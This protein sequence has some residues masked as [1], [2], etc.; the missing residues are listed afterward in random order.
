[1]TAGNVS[2]SG[3]QYVGTADDPCELV[4]VGSSKTFTDS[5]NN[6]FYGIVANL[7]GGTSTISG[8]CTID[9][10]LVSTGSV[11]LSGTASVYYDTSVV[12]QFA[13]STTTSAKI[14]PDT[15]EELSPN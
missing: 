12:S 13:S 1:V 3:S 2:I 14:V 10:A 15:W 11:S 5:G 6:P 8:S 9:G 4:M 7:T